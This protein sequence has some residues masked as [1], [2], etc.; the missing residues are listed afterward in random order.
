[1]SD[2]LKVKTPVFA[3]VLS[4][5]FPG[6]GQFYNGRV[7]SGLIFFVLGIL[8]LL[9]ILILIGWVLFPLTA[10]ISAISAYKGANSANAQFRKDL[11]KVQTQRA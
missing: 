9:S 10:V 2:A 7:V 11:G 5:I 6:L 1:M 4:A 8:T 3:L